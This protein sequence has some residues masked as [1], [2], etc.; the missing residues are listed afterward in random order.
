MMKRK[1]PPEAMGTAALELCRH[2]HFTLEANMI[3]PYIL[4][5][6]SLPTLTTNEMEWRT[7]AEMAAPP[8]STQINFALLPYHIH[9]IID[10]EQM[11]KRRYWFT[12]KWI[13]NIGRGFFFL[14]LSRLHISQ[15]AAH[16]FHFSGHFSQHVSHQCAF[17]SR[18][19][20]SLLCS[21]HT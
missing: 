16:H 8:P 15:F 6:I 21:V 3:F 20:Y 10:A 12:S 9:A 19:N 2:R 17:G 4:F 14:L 5:I 11:Y 13:G 1:E 18:L 7:W